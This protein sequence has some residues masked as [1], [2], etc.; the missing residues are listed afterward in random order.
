MTGRHRA[1]PAPLSPRSS[2]VLGLVWIALIIALSFLLA[3]I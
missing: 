1:A 2:K 3:L